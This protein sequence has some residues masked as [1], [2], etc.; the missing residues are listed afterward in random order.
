MQNRTES[1]TVVVQGLEK[2]YGPL[3]AVKGI[4]F[5]CRP[6]ELLGVLGPNGAGKT[7]TLE[8]LEGL[9][10]PDSGTV[11]IGGV[12]PERNYKRIASQMGIQLQQSAL[13][14][15]ITVKEALDLFAGYH[16]MA[17]PQGFAARMGLKGLEKRQYGQLSTGQQRR[18]SL[19]LAVLHDPPV[20]ILDEPTAG[21]DVTGRSGLHDEIKELKQA[22][23][24]ILMATHDMAEAEALC[25]RIIILL[26]GAIV[27]EGSP[28]EL[29]ARG[30]GLTKI[31]LSTAQQ[32]LSAEGAALP[33]VV[34]S[35]TDEGYTIMFSSDPAST[36]S[37]LLR[38][39]EKS[40][41]HLIDLRVQRPSLEDR[42]REITV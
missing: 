22:G 41:D 1:P 4:S 42:F 6:G 33:G 27:A 7:T 34:R 12:T 13:P 18:L 35:H 10:R 38:S 24:T 2:S 31:S 23:K 19:A 20:L 3:Q 29:T 26:E 30:G 15:S 28:M 14:E 25:D 5:Q 32:S 8:C 37:A 39:L 17:P 21:L 9:R 16:R 40:Q 11:T 36:L